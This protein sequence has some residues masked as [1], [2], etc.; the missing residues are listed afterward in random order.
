VE[1]GRERG[2]L[3]ADIQATV[4]GSADSEDE[5][6]IIA[7]LNEFNVSRGVTYNPVPL[8]VFIRDPDGSVVA[9]LVGS[10]LWDWLRISILAVDNQTRSQGYGSMLMQAAETEALKRGCK[11]AW[12]DTFS[13]Q[14]Q[15]FYEKNGYELFG[16][17]ADYPAGHTRLFLKKTLQA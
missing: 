10:T 15:A 16:E 6:A 13:F 5:S 14:A 3:M 8:S 11:Y 4:H 7:M 12:V 9:G 2:E 1:I 17:L